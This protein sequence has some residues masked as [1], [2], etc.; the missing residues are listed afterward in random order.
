M[1]KNPKTSFSFLVQTRGC[2]IVVLCHYYKARHLYFFWCRNTE[3]S[4]RYVYLFQSSFHR[5]FRIRPNCELLFTNDLNF[6]IHPLVWIFISIVLFPLKHLL[7]HRSYSSQ[8]KLKMKIKCFTLKNYIVSQKTCSFLKKEY[9][10][11]GT[12]CTIVPRLQTF[13]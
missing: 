13:L 12:S 10:F 1:N 3:F 5:P 9:F 6:S 8:L 7:Y 4:L 2:E 11:S